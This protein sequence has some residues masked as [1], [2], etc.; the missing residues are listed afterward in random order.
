MSNR[1][2]LDCANTKDA[3][4][5]PRAQQCHHIG[6]KPSQLLGQQLDERKIALAVNAHY[7]LVSIRLRGFGEQSSCL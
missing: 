4:P 3:A 5:T 2:P 6:L 1:K 7:Q